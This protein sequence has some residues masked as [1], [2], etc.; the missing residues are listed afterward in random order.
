MEKN[1]Y[2]DTTIFASSNEQ[3]FTKIDV[4]KLKK[5][6]HKI[7]YKDV[8][9]KVIKNI[10]YNKEIYN[11]YNLMIK[12]NNN[13]LFNKY[14]KL[15]FHLENNYYY[16]IY[17]SIEKYV[18]NE[19]YYIIND[20]ILFLNLKL[21]N[22]SFL[23]EMKIAI[24][25]V[26]PIKLK[27]KK[28]KLNYLKTLLY[29]FPLYSFIYK[30]INIGE[31]LCDIIKDRNFKRTYNYVPIEK[32]NFNTDKNISNLKHLDNIYKT[33]E[34]ETNDLDRYIINKSNLKD[35]NDIYKTLEEVNKIINNL[36]IK[37]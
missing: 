36:E 3:K 23:K 32:I 24:L 35:L 20:I 18:I 29:S 9:K 27:Y 8:S 21:N 10:C 26:F 7:Y 16:N 31:A 34:V 1:T 12:Y 33:L 11:D 14:L 28:K 17:I 25:N 4:R 19:I 22:I 6:I 15:Q 5:K 30:K 37:K 13:N 2:I